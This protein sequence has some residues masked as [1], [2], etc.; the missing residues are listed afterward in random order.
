MKMIDVMIVMM[1]ILFSFVPNFSDV[2]PFFQS[3]FKTL[4]KPQLRPRPRR[5]SPSDA[6]KIKSGI[7]RALSLGKQH[8]FKEAR[9]VLDDLEPCTEVDTAREVL[10]LCEEAQAGEGK[11]TLL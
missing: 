7:N 11:Q 9:H 4:E 2:F 3:R 1:I 6:V 8:R 10:K 5:D